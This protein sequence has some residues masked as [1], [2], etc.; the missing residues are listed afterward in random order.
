MKKSFNLLKEKIALPR[1][2][3]LLT[4]V[5]FFQI[6]TFS[7]L[8]LF[9]VADETNKNKNITRI[10]IIIDDIGYSFER[11]KQAAKLPGAVTLAIIPHT[12]NSVS[13]ANL[14]HELNKEIMLHIPMSNLLNKPLDEGAL[15]YGMGYFL[16]L[17]T[18]RQDLKAVPHV[19]GV[20]NHMGSLLTQQEAPMRWLMEELSVKELFFIDSRTSSESIA[21]QMA[22][23]AHIPSAKRDYFLDNDR[24]Y[25][26]IARQFGKFISTAQKRGTGVAIAHPYPE[27]LHFL[28]QTI[29][30]LK[31]LNIHLVPVSSLLSSF[32]N[33]LQKRTS[34]LKPSNDEGFDY[35]SPYFLRK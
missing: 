3:L 31:A 23:K 20:N 15:T 30:K 4:T 10:A 35:F 14:G 5:L 9:A 16:F 11:G 27:T 25:I 13:L 7:S 18:L 26:S 32:D 8:S 34:R 17:D 12:T 28:E 2:I 21:W 6:S 22:Q 24:D 29:P 33:I 19:R 1:K